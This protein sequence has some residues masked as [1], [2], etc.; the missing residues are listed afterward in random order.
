ME[1]LR[2]ISWAKTKHAPLGNIPYAYLQLLYSLCITSIL[3]LIFLLVRL[4]GGI[5]TAGRVEV[6]HNGQWGTVCD[7]HW[8]I[9]EATVVCHQL[10][11]LAALDAS[12][13]FGLGEG[14]I[15]FDDLACIGEE[16]S[17]FTCPRSSHPHNCGHSEDAGVVCLSGKLCNF[18]DHLLFPLRK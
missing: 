4:A 8:G 6:F 17:I 9:A 11:F 1:K 15:H 3:S 18:L 5:K 13:K 12:T 2:A 16:T 10:G 14:P 7:D